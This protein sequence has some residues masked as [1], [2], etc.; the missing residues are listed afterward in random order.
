MKIAVFGVALLLSLSC[1]AA[2]W[3]LLGG[4]AHNIAIYVDLKV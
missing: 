3:K 2:N 1:F 4:Q